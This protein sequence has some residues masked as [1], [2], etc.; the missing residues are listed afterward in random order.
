[1]L[2][3][4]ELSFSV[5]IQS[6]II[7]IYLQKTFAPSYLISW[8]KLKHVNQIC[9]EQKKCT[10]NR[11]RQ[12][13]KNEDRMLNGETEQNLSQEDCKYMR[14]LGE[15]IWFLHPDTIGISVNIAAFGIGGGCDDDAFAAL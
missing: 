9:E 14:Q 1:M 12:S 15:T 2:L 5:Q 7:H 6:N 3:P 13:K 8:I 10:Q 4:R 11:A